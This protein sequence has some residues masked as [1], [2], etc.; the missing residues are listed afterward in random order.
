M[1]AVGFT[2]LTGAQ[3]SV[4]GAHTVLPSVRRKHQVICWSYDQWCRSL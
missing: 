2:Q 3:I 1:Y 4:L